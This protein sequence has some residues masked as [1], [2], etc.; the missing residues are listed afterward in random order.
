MKFLS[1][2]ITFATTSFSFSAVLILFTTSLSLAADNFTLRR[3]ANNYYSDIQLQRYL[4]KANHRSAVTHSLL[5]ELKLQNHCNDNPNISPK[6]CIETVCSKVSKY[7]CDDV[8]EI[9]QIAGFC[10]H[11]VDGDCIDAVCAKVSKYDCDDLSEV[12]E[13]ANMCS[14]QYSAKC[15]DTACSYLDKFSCDDL[16]ETKDIIA[17][18]CTPDVDPDCIKSVC[19]KLSKYDCDDLSELKTIAKACSSN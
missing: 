8:S 12:K 13:V 2:I 16:S 15:F 19:S 4:K 10:K 5:R 17:N 6:S 3:H 7:D 18:V 1:T 11:N 9:Q 14:S